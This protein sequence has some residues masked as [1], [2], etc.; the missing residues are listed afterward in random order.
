[1]QGPEPRPIL[2]RQ[3]PQVVLYQICLPVCIP[4]APS[5][6]PSLPSGLSTGTHRRSLC[7]GSGPT[8]P[9]A[10]AAGQSSSLCRAHCT[11]HRPHS[12]ASPDCLCALGSR[13]PHTQKKAGHPTEI[14]NPTGLAGSGADVLGPGGGERGDSGSFFMAEEPLL[15]KRLE[16][17]ICR[18]RK[19]FSPGHITLS[20]QLHQVGLAAPLIKLGL[21]TVFRVKKAS[22]L[23]TVLPHPRSIIY[24]V[25]KT[26]PCRQRSI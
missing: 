13:T 24:M 21:R 11:L 22:V 9:P 7:R 18:S 26:S 17:T 25:K 19:S 5:T 12:T 10:A 4:S 20:C 14:Q 3:S 2:P 8:P 15:T 6:C 16:F 1:M 23:T